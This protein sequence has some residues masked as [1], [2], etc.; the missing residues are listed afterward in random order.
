MPWSERYCRKDRE[1]S[2]ASPTRVSPAA[3]T[4]LRFQAIPIITST[5]VAEITRIGSKAMMSRAFIMNVH[6]RKDAIGNCT[7]KLSKAWAEALSTGC[8]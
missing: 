2:P 7:W 4:G 1:E 5:A 8:G 3:R 6:L